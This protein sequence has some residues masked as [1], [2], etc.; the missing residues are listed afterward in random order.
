MRAPKFPN[1][2]Q[3]LCGIGVVAPI[4]V[5]TVP[6]ENSFHFYTEQGKYTGI[7]ANGTVEFAEKIRSITMLAR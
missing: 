6:F 1:K 7:T 5:N 2:S 3:T 4:H